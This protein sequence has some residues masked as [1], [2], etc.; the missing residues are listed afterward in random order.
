MTTFEGDNTV[1]AQQSARFILK[2]IK[3]IHKGFKTTG[4]FKY[5][6]NVDSLL[7]TKCAAK[8]IEQMSDLN[9]LQEALQVRSAYYANETFK[10]L[11]SSNASEN[12]KTNNLFAVDIISMTRAHIL[13]VTF[14]NFKDAI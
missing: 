4:L 12:E 13:Y 3:N 8:T 11:N 6:N 14:K 5:L 9:I 10:K 7:S 2:N 1:L